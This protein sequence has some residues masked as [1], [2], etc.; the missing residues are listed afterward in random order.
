MVII[1]AIFEQ[2]ER[3]IIVSGDKAVVVGPGPEVT[4]EGDF[5]WLNRKRTWAMVGIATYT[6]CKVIY[7]ET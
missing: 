7:H 3:L 6:K 1:K 4:G 5:S 2:S